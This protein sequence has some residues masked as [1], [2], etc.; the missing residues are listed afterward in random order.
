MLSLIGYLLIGGGM[1]LLA[2]LSA[3]LC[4]NFLVKFP[5]ISI[6][7]ALIGLGIITGKIIYEIL[8]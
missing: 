1:L 4:A 6:V 2:I 3:Y 7:I 5:I 8:N